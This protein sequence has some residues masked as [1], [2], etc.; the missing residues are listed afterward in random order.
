MP[1]T[2]NPSG[3]Q[4]EDIFNRTQ[5]GVFVM[6]RDRQIILFNAACE[7]LTGF[8]KEEV[9]GTRCHCHD[10]T[11]CHDEYGR[12]LT[13]KL[14]PGLQIFN[15]KGKTAKQCMRVRRRDG[16]YVWIEMTYTPLPDNEGKVSCVLAVMHDISEIKEKE[17]ELQAITEN[18]REE[19]ERLRG[20]IRQEY[21]FS[22]IVSRSP[23]MREV[24]AKIRAAGDS[25]SAVLI[26]GEAGTG[27]E[28]IARTIHDNGAQKDGPFVPANCAALTPN[29]IE[30]ELFGYVRGA[31]D[32]ANI[33]FDGLFRAAERG[34][35]FLDDVTELPVD[36]QAKLLRVLED[37]RV[38]PVGSTREVTVDTRVVAATSENLAGAVADGS[39][40]KD[41]FYRLSVVNIEVPPLR[42]RKED[43]PFLVEHFIGQFNRQNVREVRE[44]AQD[45]WPM[46]LR[47]DWPGNVRELQNAVESAFA[48]GSGA[49]LKAADLPNLVR[50]E[51]IEV[52]DNADRPDM[53]LD[54]VLATVERRAI[55]AALRRAGG[56]RSKAARTIGISRSRLYRRMEALGIRPREDL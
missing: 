21:G 14:C 48:I 32:G 56:Q 6:D 46:L 15:G 9:V 50:G 24:F 11:D 1:V 49:V 31:F 36:T 42:D 23:K 3:V 26:S 27:K 17:Q 41:L 45:V 16:K 18:L 28:I 43:I 25:Q 10:L 7:R 2:V 29:L 13:G 8:R 55:L 52:R 39:L 54:E 47:Y 5:D 40:R 12:S 22:T 51:T 35:I 33:D 53:P 37:K 34:T 20:D 44:V 19:V 4:L 30:S 38:R